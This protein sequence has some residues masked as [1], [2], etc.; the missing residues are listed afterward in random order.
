MRQRRGKGARLAGMN[1]NEVFVIR[2]TAV[3]TKCETRSP[4]ATTVTAEGY[5]A[6]TT[7][8]NHR[9]VVC[10]TP[11]YKRMVNGPPCHTVATPGGAFGVNATE[12]QRNNERLTKI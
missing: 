11:T 4:A 10:E 7:V 1:G 5:P 6:F 12:C 9:N 3:V 2:A 8:N